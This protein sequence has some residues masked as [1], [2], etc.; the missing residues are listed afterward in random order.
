MVPYAESCAVVEIHAN[1]HG[2]NMYY[3][4]VTG[5]LLVVNHHCHLNNTRLSSNLLIF[6]VE[7]ALDLPLDCTLIHIVSAQVWRHGLFWAPLCK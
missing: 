6:P 2:M 1:G 5:Y 3:L 4:L 7:E